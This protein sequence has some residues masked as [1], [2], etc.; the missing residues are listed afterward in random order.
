V[1]RADKAAC[2]SSNHI[3]ADV[4]IPLALTKIKV[5]PRRLPTP[6]LSVEI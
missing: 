2:R 5:S 4:Q 1:N 3:E 6:G